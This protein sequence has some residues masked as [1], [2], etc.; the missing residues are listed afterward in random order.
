MTLHKPTARSAFLLPADCILVWGL[1]VCC[2]AYGQVAVPEEEVRVHDLPLLTA[3]SPAASEVLATSLAIILHDKDICCGRN[4]ALGDSVRAAA[5]ESL[6]DIAG[7][8]QGRHI[9][10][11]GRPIMV[12]AEYLTP[13]QV[14]SG[15]LIYMLMQKHAALMLWNSH[16]YV[17]DGVTYIKTISGGVDGPGGYVIYTIHKL[18]LQD[19]RFSDSRRT[20]SFD[21]TTDEV[22]KVQGMLFLQAA[23]Q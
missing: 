1:A 8:L 15:H 6:K 10:S 12:T 4:S 16:L 14:S 7:K 2:L 23:L 21:R 5:P 13:D 3:P 18:L 20:V 22:S 9:L 11:D 19:A 17:V